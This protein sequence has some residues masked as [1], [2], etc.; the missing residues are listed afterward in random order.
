MKDLF[1]SKVVVLGTSCLV[2]AGAIGG[3]FWLWDR[4]ADTTDALSAYEIGEMHLAQD[5]LNEISGSI[6]RYKLHLYQSY[7]DRSLG[8]LQQ[9]GRELDRA[10]ASGRKSAKT[11]FL[12][13]V[14]AGK[15]LNAYLGNDYKKLYSALAQ[16]YKQDPESKWVPFFSGIINLREE[17]YAEALQDWIASEGKKMLSPWM[18]T[19]FNS[20]FT[21]LWQTMQI[22]QSEMGIGNRLAARQRLLAA[23]D[24]SEDLSTTAEINFLI[25]KTYYHEALSYSPSAAI[26]YFK[27]AFL[28][29]DKVPVDEIHNPY[30]M[31]QILQSVN[32]FATQLIQS[33]HDESVAFYIDTLESHGK[34]QA[35]EK[36]YQMQ[37][38]KLVKAIDEGNE[39]EISRLSGLISVNEMTANSLEK[40]QEAIQEKMSLALQSENFPRLHNLLELDL[41]YSTNPENT[42]NS[43]SK[44]LQI[45]ALNKLEN[46]NSDFEAT[47]P[48][49]ELIQA[50]KTPPEKQLNFGKEL[51]HIA[52]K[53]WVDK[54]QVNKAIAILNKAIE[55][56]PNLQAHL[57][58]VLN[59]SYQSATAAKNFDTIENLIDVANALNINMETFKSPQAIESQL[60]YATDLYLSEEL[61]EAIN[62]INIL[63]KISP[64]NQE[65]LLLAGMTAYKM[66]DHEKTLTYLREVSSLP[67]FA[68]EA[69]AISEIT[70][71]DNSEGINLLNSIEDKSSFDDETYIQIALG[72]LNKG[73][74]EQAIDWLDKI[75][76]PNDMTLTAQLIA[77]HNNR[78]WDTAIDLYSRLS[79]PYVLL[80]GV[81]AAIVDA[82]AQQGKLEKA[83]ELINV[84]L[85]APEQ[86]LPE[87]FPDT[88]ITFK[89]E[90]LDPWDRYSTAG[91]FYKHVKKDS[92]KAI[93]F[94][95]Q[96]KD[97]DPNVLLERGEIYY[98]AGQYEKALQDFISASEKADDKEVK[99]EALSSLGIVY[100]TL[101]QFPN[102]YLAFKEFYEL[103]PEDTSFRSSFADVLMKIGNFH[104]ALVQYEYLE[105][106]Q[107]LTDDDQI[108]FVKAW[109][110]FG[111][112]KETRKEGTR[113]AKDSSF[114]LAQRMEID[115]IILPATHQPVNK[116]TLKKLEKSKTPLS[117]KLS[118]SVLRI[119]LETGDFESAEDFVHKQKSLLENS[120]N[121]LYLLSK[122][123]LQ[124]GNFTKGI[125]ALKRAIDLAPKNI[126]YRITIA[127]ESKDPDSLKPIIDELDGLIQEKE[128]T[129]SQK[130]DYAKFQ[131]T[132]LE[133]QENLLP[134]ENFD[135]EWKKLNTLLRNIHKTYAELPEVKILLGRTHQMLREYSDALD[136]YGEALLVDHSN[137]N[138]Y[139]WGAEIYAEQKK[140]NTATPLINQALKFQPWNSDAWTMKAHYEELD[141]NTEAA[142]TALQEALKFNPSNTTSQIA[143]GTLYLRVNNPEDARYHLEQAVENDPLN[144][145]ALSLLLKT[146]YDPFL[147]LTTDDK[148][149]LKAERDSTYQ[150]LHQVDPEYAE[151]WLTEIEK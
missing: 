95:S 119:F 3:G 30:E 64:Q 38:D 116:S 75:K 115:A 69:L 131:I 53:N 5:E 87:E 145:E 91:L 7:I 37:V 9:S 15:C 23:L 58:G 76:Q 43:F 34:K 4:E 36:L 50:L 143:L 117:G 55:I 74:T 57:Q 16:L 79:A 134:E 110:N 24:A 47:T 129:L 96:S 121:G 72:L 124:N 114:S 99:T 63:L 70:S 135:E 39:Q 60:A 141:G 112:F 77:A 147:E 150:L 146:L 35:A 139:L 10:W 132:Y 14:A 29:I 94:L 27:V 26:P 144:S 103:N 28:Y 123:Y 82:Y 101:R 46:D 44:E 140:L 128:A 18:E 107:L 56:S 105:E 40:I 54:K 25:G 85:A 13:E 59:S 127:K 109:L 11:A 73:E 66:G 80:D 51:I 17:K 6:P 89:H 92:K 1:K 12:T 71:G 45:A 2:S 133:M 83:E 20:V 97:P 138:A 113:I 31:E 65:A 98:H 90:V 137:V 78:K 49:F 125:N 22:A 126:S 61:E 67:D 149:Q 8:N 106:K 93:K 102:S 130:I 62:Q 84:L 81:Q 68:L 142:I 120:E 42:L 19:S 148:E 86:P 32:S 118:E 122:F 104:D 151:K 48:Y 41:I 111:D 108:Q 88:F 33:D 100:K 136:L 21:P 52:E